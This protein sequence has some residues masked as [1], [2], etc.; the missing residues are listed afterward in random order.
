MTA[1]DRPRVPHVQATRASAPPRWAVLERELFAV[2]DRAWRVFSDRYTE[3]D[4]RLVFRDTLG[5]GLDGRDGVDDFYE[6]FFNWPTLYLLGG[7]TDVLTASRRHWRGVTGQLTE[8]GMLVDGFERGYDWF[9]QGEG[10]LLF[11]GLCLAAPEDRE[12][13]ELATRFA[14]LYLPGGPNYDP[15]HRIIRAPHNGAGGPRWGFSDHD[16]YFPWSLALRPYGLPLDWIDGVTSFDELAADPQR[17]RAY[18]RIMWDRMGRG[19]T[20]VNLAATSLVTNAYLLGGERRH[21]DWVVEYVDA[22]RERLDGRDVVP[23][24][25]GTHGVVGEHLEGRWYGGHY[26]WSWPHGLAPVGTAAIV[27]AVNAVLLTGDEG[28]LDLAR[29]PM[30]A[31][32][33]QAE[34]LRPADVTT[35]TKR[36]RPHLRGLENEPTLMAPMRRDD[37]GWFDHNI[38]PTQ[39]PVALWQFGR[40]AADRERIDHL[41]KASSWDWTVVH[42]QRTKEEAGHEEPWYEYLAGR[43]PGFPERM[44]Q[45]AADA[46]AQRLE[47]IEND[48]VDPAVGPDA[49]GIHDWQN[50]NPVVTEA[51]L[52][53]TTGSPQI[54]Y[55]GALAQMHLRYFDA[56][57]RRPGLPADVAALVSGIDADRTVVELV[58]LGTAPQSVVVQ[59]GTFAEHLVH[60]VS[61]D[62]QPPE[63]AGS[64]YVSVRL[65][66]STQVRLTLTMTLRGA[67]PTYRAPWEVTG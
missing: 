10:M 65:P 24:N 13:R 30:D 44:L 21:A 19:D 26:G 62:D 25:A 34:Q 15:A 53:L 20:I 1:P 5:Q 50:H 39:L 36:W 51:L 11:Y 63:Q 57:R 27:G 59:A 64:P 28:Y 45:S 40:A 31:V 42:T 23:D 18:G 16:V 58:N 46:C 48:P 2:L 37:S 55:N 7:S 52:Q 14:D 47:A 4:G 67:T 22:W 29:N 8:M 41:R 33:D 3:G 32:L 17:A 12:L 56:G 6:A 38:M 43:N 54:L 49:F 35:I 61:A 9:H 60:T 66:G